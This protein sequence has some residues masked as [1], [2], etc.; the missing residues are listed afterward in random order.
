MNI[1]LDLALRSLSDATKKEYASKVRAYR[2]FCILWNIHPWTK[3]SVENY[4]FA[5]FKKGNSIACPH[6]F[7]S[8]LR[9]LT[10]VAGVDDLFSPRANMMIDSFA[11]DERVKRNRFIL[12][13]L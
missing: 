9:K 3:A 6:T 10:D 4:I 7:R 12:I 8:A 5:M 1:F 11:L 13:S 2:F